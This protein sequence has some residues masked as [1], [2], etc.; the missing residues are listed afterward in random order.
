MIELGLGHGFGSDHLKIGSVKM[1]QD[2]SIQALT[3]AL[4]Q[5]YYNK[6]GFRGELIMPQAAMESLVEKYHKEELQVAVHANGDAAIES[7][8]LAMEKAQAKCPPS[9]SAT[10]DH[11]LPNRYG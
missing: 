11:P 1:F 3:A 5:D 9:R 10:H 6:P 4:S 8:I 7:V 2:G